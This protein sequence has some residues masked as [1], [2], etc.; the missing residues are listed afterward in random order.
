MKPLRRSPLAWAFAPALLL[1]LYGGYL[2]MS[3]RPQRGLPEKAIT[4]TNG[5]GAVV[6]FVVEMA[7]TPAEREKGL[8]FRRSLAADSGMLFMF[9]KAE[10]V[11]FWMKDTILPLDMIFIR[12]NGVVDSIARDQ[13]PFSLANTFSTGPVIAAL[14]IP[15]GSSDRLG[16]KAGDKVTW[17]GS[18]LPLL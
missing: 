2:K 4:V 8:M 13:P 1:V 17:F 7:M 16:L 9:P 18:R 3:E 10:V 5:R 15:A 12:A 6:R 14:E 11:D